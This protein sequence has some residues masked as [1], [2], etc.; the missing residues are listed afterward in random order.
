MDRGF[1]GGYVLLA[2]VEA[3]ECFIYIKRNSKNLED[4]FI[5]EDK[6]S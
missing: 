1:K 5:S 3:R 4:R 2:R 6:G